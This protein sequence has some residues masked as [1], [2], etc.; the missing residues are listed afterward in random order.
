[1][2][3]LLITITAILLTAG[4]TYAA[5]KYVKTIQVDTV[6]ILSNQALTEKGY[7]LMKVTDPTNDTDCYLLNASAISCYPKR[8]SVN[9]YPN[10]N[11]GGN[12]GGVPAYLK[13]TSKIQ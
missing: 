1:M 3:T 13:S 8:E 2:K 4:T 6:T 11:A 5:V 12:Q 7:T 9:V 10:G